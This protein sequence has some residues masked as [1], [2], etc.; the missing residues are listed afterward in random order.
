MANYVV[1][2]KDQL[3]ANLTTVAD[4]IRTKGGT[5]EQ[6]VFPDGF[7]SAVESI[8]T[9]DSAKE[10]QEKTVDITENGTTEVIPDSGKVLSKVT[11]NTNVASGGSSEEYELFKKQMIERSITEIVVPSGITKIGHSAFR[12]CTS[13]T[14]IVLPEGVTLIDHSAFSNIL[15]IDFTELPNSVT[16]IKDQGFNSSTFVNK[17]L[18]LPDSLQTVA[19]QVFQYCNGVAIKE[20]PQ[21]VVS[22]GKQAFQNCTEITEL[23]F[24]GTPTTIQ[25]NSFQGCTNLTVIN[26]P[27][28]EGAVANAPWGATNATINYNYVG[29]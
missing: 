23:T 24:K 26:V 25:S 15:Y 14:R 16:I 19:N 8:Q 17:L 13:L 27:W 4:S 12:G 9:G 11:V 21:S 22:I 20:I 2:D 5:T 3:E 7:V 28:S 1:V 18:K 10:E 6:L 29:A